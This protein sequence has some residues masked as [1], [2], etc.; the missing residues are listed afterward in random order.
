[1]L[2][3]IG[4]VALSVFIVGVYLL[5]IY[6][7][8]KRHAEVWEAVDNMAHILKALTEEQQR[9]VGFLD[10]WIPQ[11]DQLPFW[12]EHIHW[13][14]KRSHVMIRSLRVTCRCGEFKKEEP[15]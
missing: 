2:T 1:M 15:Q 3:T 10:A 5:L 13:W 11:A 14:V 7:E 12:G 9:I 6:R 8:D 4:I